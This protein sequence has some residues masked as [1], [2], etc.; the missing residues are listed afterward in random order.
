[1]ATTHDM[2][3]EGQDTRRSVWSWLVPLAIIL[4]AAIAIASYLGSRP[5]TNS[6]LNFGT[7]TTVNTTP[8][9]AY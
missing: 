2:R 8:S 5:T 4:L 6:D 9:T 1:M 3:Y 7:G